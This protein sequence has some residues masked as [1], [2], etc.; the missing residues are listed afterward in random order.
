MY[1]LITG[2]LVFVGCIS[3]VRAV[4]SI[5]DYL[6]VPVVLPHILSIVYLSYKQ[7]SL[8]E[9]AEPVLADAA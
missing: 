5:V 9:G 4:W 1:Y 7:G 6:L 8:L 2:A 3:D